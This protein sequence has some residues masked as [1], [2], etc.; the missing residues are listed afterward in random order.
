[1]PDEFAALKPDETRLNQLHI[2]WLSGATVS[3]ILPILGQWKRL[4]HLVLEP[5]TYESGPAPN[6]QGLQTLITRLPEL[7]SLRIAGFTTTRP[8]FE[9]LTLAF[10]DYLN[11]H[12]PYFK[13]SF[14]PNIL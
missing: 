3:Q 8:E 10:T 9:L 7:R 12:R 2:S 5:S 6:M 14:M 11:V 13:F 4:Q 1:V